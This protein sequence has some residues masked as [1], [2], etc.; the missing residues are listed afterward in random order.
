M[1]AIEVIV[2]PMNPSEKYELDKIV[3]QIVVPVK[4]TLR[5]DYP[6]CIFTCGVTNL[7]PVIPDERAGVVLVLTVNLTSLARL[8]MQQAARVK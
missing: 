8:W 2:S 6:R 5:K 3:D 4:S 7:T 1:Y